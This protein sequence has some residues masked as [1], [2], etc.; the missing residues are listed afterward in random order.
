[1]RVQLSQIMTFLIFFIFLKNYILHL[2]SSNKFF[3]CFS[4]IN[5]FCGFLRA[6]Q[7]EANPPPWKEQKLAC[8]PEY[9]PSTYIN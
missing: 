9:A 2:A 5:G 8:P 1:M 4:K 7:C 6:Q 3:N